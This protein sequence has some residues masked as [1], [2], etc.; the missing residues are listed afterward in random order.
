MRLIARPRSYWYWL[1]YAVLWIDLVA[2]YTRGLWIGG[3][4]AV[5]VIVALAAPTL[6]R[7]LIFSGVTVAGFAV[8]LIIMPAA[9]FS[10][11]NYVL[12]R[13]HRSPTRA[14]LNTRWPSLTRA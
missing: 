2:T 10:L 8:A 4:A 6:R 12:K 5:V 9:G 14:R 13:T 7:A 11:S 1:L 3:V